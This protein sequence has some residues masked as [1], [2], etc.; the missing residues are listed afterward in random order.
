MRLNI[1]EYFEKELTGKKDYSNNFDNNTQTLKKYEKP[2][3]LDFGGN[4]IRTSDNSGNY[5]CTPGSAGHRYD[6]MSG[7]NGYP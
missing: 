5:F 1:M 6:C 2:E 3:L 7:F 4:L